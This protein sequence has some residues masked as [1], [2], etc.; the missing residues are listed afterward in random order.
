LDNQ[1]SQLREQ[2]KACLVGAYGISEA[3]P[4]S[5]DDQAHLVQQVMS[6]QPGF[7]PRLPHGTTMGKALEQLLG[8][9]LAF[10]YPDHPEFDTE[11][12]IT[13]LAKVLTELRRALLADN[14]R[15]DVDGPLR[16]LMRQIAQPLGLGDMHERHFILKTDW[17]QQLSRELAKAGE[18][19]TVKALRQA[20]DQPKPKGLTTAVQNLLILV[21]A[22]HGHYA[23]NLH[24]G[25][26]QDVTIKDIRDDLTLIKQALA[27]PQQ[28]K[29]AL[30]N[31]AA[32]F[33][34]TINPH[35]T[36][37]NQNTLQTQ[38]REEVAQ[39][40]DDCHTLASDLERQLS[41]LDLRVEGN[42]IDSARRAVALLEAL[43]AKEDIDL[44]EE[45]AD[46][47]PAASLAPLAKSIKEAARVSHTISDNNW[48]LLETV[49]KGADPEAAAIKQRVAEALRTDELVT[50]LANALR[51]AQAD[52]T[53]IITRQAPPPPKP[54][55]PPKP[56]T[57]TSKGR[58][59]LRKGDRRGLS[60]QET[61]QVLADI[62]ADL[63]EGVVVDIT[64][65]IVGDSSG[66]GAS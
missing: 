10:Q 16:P 13:D 47:K 65:Q 38:V 51:Q 54:T 18:A 5:V 55:D 34:L 23:F 61:R 9:A 27:P 20:M 15:I 29:A 21:F 43:Q 60:Q 49:W 31:A 11:V 33:G 64:Y 8:Q 62:E 3:L 30:D 2:M 40:L 56:P 50:S 45:L 25:P 28:W 44:V 46:I 41:A 24:G 52:A 66:E 14:G 4:G 39:Y 17:P 35:R 58:K 6:L 7:T 42:R 53:R 12:R 1:R 48:A 32:L 36:A 26:Y 19:V 59:V 63:H 37:T 22:E 57:P